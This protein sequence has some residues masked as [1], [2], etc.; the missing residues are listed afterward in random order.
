VLAEWGLRESQRT[1]LSDRQV[2]G[3]RGK[4][5]RR[6]ILIGVWGEKDIPDELWSGYLGD[7]S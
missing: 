1:T 7:R 2:R 3:K 6:G 5:Q 4:V